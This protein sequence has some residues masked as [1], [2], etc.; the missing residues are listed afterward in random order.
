MF[1][2]LETGRADGRYAR[3]FR[4]LTRVNFLILDDWGSSAQSRDP[5]EIIKDR[6]QS[7]S[8]LSGSGKETATHCRYGGAVCW[9]RGRDTTFTEQC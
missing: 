3:L 9:L 5:M 2:E 6:D 1:A 8:I 4:T 7:T